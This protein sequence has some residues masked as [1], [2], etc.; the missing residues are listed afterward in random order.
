MLSAIKKF[1]QE[2]IQGGQ[3]PTS[4]S[5][6]SLQLAAA[7]LL[8]EVM[9]ADHEESEQERQVVAD[10]LQRSLNVTAEETEQLIGL[11]EQEVDEAVSLFQ[12]TELIDKQFAYHEKIKLLE[13]MWQVVF[14]D[15]L[16]DKHEEYLVRKIADLLHISHRDYIQA[17]HHI[18]A[19]LYNNQLNET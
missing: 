11:A 2:Q 9:R 8:I 4:H 15:A 1:F 7:A 16:K 19:L 13:M 6:H 12:F 5:Q 18:E 3:T 10:V 14:A 17:R